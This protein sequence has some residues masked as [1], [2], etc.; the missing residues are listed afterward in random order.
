MIAMASPQTTNA[1][2]AG[3]DPDQ[4]EI[5]L[6]LGLPRVRQLLT[7]KETADYLRVDIDHVYHFLDDGELTGEN[8]ARKTKGETPTGRARQRYIRVHR[9][10]AIDLRR[11]RRIES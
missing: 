3:N 6:E 11:R 5:D 10:S 4:M 2:Q 7:V 1:R 8:L 9:Q